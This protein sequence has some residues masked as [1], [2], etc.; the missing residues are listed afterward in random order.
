[1]KLKLRIL[2]GSNAGLELSI[3]RNKTFFGRGE[4]CDLRLSDSSVSRQHCLIRI[5]DNRVVIRDL[6]SR[7]GTYVNEQR[8]SGDRELSHNDHIKIGKFEFELLIL[9]DEAGTANQSS[10]TPVQENTRLPTDTVP[11]D[12]PAA[13]VLRALNGP[14][15]GAVIE[16]KGPVLSIGRAK[17][18][19]Y[20]PKHT[21][22]SR[23]HCELHVVDGRAIVRD[24]QSRNGTFVND[25]QIKGEAR[26]VDGDELRLGE[27]IL[28]VTITPTDLD[29]DADVSNENAL[30]SEVLQRD[31]S[32][33][34][35][36]WEAELTAE[37]Q[38]FEASVES[39]K[40]TTSEELTKLAE[41]ADTSK[42]QQNADT[43]GSSAESKSGSQHKPKKKK[44]KK[45]NG[46]K[47]WSRKTWH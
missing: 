28:F 22:V 7:K 19:D 40:D 23:C 9:L 36:S 37:L 1:M 27:L 21:S 15:E 30:E 35:D 33:I 38:R 42:S 5:S 4:A 34:A 41:D 25:E 46:P 44:K 43:S 14:D 11:N 10:S 20:R 2:N 3:G 29:S 47:P 31:G 45:N 8:I 39:L 17:D 24:L 26:L 18:S 6:G 12:S 13:M 16:V 32:R